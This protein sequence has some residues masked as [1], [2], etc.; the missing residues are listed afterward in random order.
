[1]KRIFSLL[2]LLFIFS[3]CFSGDISVHAAEESLDNMLNDDFLDDED[4]KEKTIYDPLEPMNR[5]FF[6]VNDKLYY[7]VIKPVNK[8][9]SAILP[10]DIRGCVGNFYT[11]LGTP[12]RALNNLLQGDFKDAGIVLSRFMINST[13]GVFGFA[14]PAYNEFNLA[15][16][17]AD[18]GETLG[19]FGVGEGVYLYWP[20]IG[21]SNVRDLAGF[22]VDGYAHPV[23]YLSTKITTDLLYYTVKQ[24]NVFS[25]KPD[26]YDDMKKF[27]LD[28][29]IATRQAY[30]DYRREKVNRGL[31][32][33]LK[34]KSFE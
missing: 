5:F 23:P 20:I 25:L 4:G 14:D 7:W 3:P 6:Q 30:T 15:P 17:S 29:Y 1:M 24:I 11:N 9:Y 19:K 13:F 18:F 31:N 10:V 21:P 16:R 27:S 26:L 34:F 28:P 2:F 32:F 22:V 12:I 8:V 33:K